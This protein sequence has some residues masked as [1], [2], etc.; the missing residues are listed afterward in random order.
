MQQGFFGVFKNCEAVYGAQLPGLQFKQLVGG[1]SCEVMHC[2]G[3][4]TCF[5]SC[6]L[7]ISA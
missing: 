3:K 7:V 1:R 5:E 4:G 2:C 6:Q